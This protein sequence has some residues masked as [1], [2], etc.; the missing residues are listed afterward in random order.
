M[1]KSKAKLSTIFTVF[2]F[3]A[4]AS[5]DYAVIGLFPPL[6]SSIAN[7]LNVH[8]SV[9]GSVSAVTILFT[10]LS[11]IAWGYLADKGN[12]KRL[13]IIG[14]LI[15]SLSLFLSS[16]SQSYFHLVVFQIFT[17]LGLG[18]N[19]SIG[20]SVLTD[21]VPK[22]YLGTIMSLW[23]LSQGFGCI[24]GSVMAPIVSS[25]LGWRIPF[26]IISFLGVLFIFLYFF[27]KEPVKGAAEPEL[28]GV[29]FKSY[30][31]NISLL[32]IKNILTKKSNFWLMI[33]GFFLNITLGTLL[34]LPTLYTAKIK[35]QGYSEETSLIAASYFYAL[36]QL[37]GLSSTYFGYLGDKLQKKT[38]R[39]R[40]LLTA[41]SYF[42]SYPFIY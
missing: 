42:S 36:F 2:I 16:L 27:V 29:K 37:G 14:T 7:S 38:L 6:F 24:A 39:A 26:M 28:R 21:Y 23:G 19:S 13:I 8:I 18:C 25:K 3:I 10:A 32:G 4:L 35:A 17:G 30:N 20:F 40:A 11:S 9:M 22:K 5:L 34:W 15:W 12:R 41:L 33:Q 1:I 31:Y